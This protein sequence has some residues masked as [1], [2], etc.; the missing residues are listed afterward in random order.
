LLLL[1]G[2]TSALDHPQ[3]IARFARPSVCL[4][5]LSALKDTPEIAINNDQMKNVC[6]RE[7][8]ADY[9]VE[10]GGSHLAEQTSAAK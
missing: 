9:K 10:Y 7:F 5:E 3:P 2:T 4:I 6:D 1:E 8:M